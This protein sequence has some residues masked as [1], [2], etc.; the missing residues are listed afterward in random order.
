MKN[1]VKK[2]KEWYKTF[3]KTWKVIQPFFYSSE[4]TRKNADFI[5]KVLNLKKGLKVLDVPCGNGR[6]G[7]ELAKKGCVVT[8][9]DFNENIIEKAKQASKKRKLK[10]DFHI[11]DMR[12]ISWKNKFD[13][14]ICWWGSFGYFNEKGNRNFIKAVSSSLKKGGRF[15]I[16]TH[17][18]E[19]LLPKYQSRGWENFGNIKVLEDRRFDFVNSRII[20]DWIFIKDGKEIKRTSSI[21][22]YTYKELTALL[23]KFC[24]GNFKSYGSCNIKDDVFFGKRLI[25][26]AEKI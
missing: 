9:I 2:N 12:K 15:I 24:F 1:K 16:D 14:A 5:W 7:F 25:L 10:V 19:T 4:Q 23:R 22:L 13:A 17:T 11:G 3:F 6:I 8:G 26:T 20:V 18:M 21:Q